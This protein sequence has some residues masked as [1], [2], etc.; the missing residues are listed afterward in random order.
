MKR[1]V[2]NLLVSAALLAAVVWFL[3]GK[4]EQFDA[5]SAFSTRECDTSAVLLGQDVE[6]LK[7]PNG[8]TVATLKAGRPIYL[9]ASEN[10]HRRVVFPN[11][12]TAADCTS[13]TSNTCLSGFVKEP[14]ETTILG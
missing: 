14:F 9:C 3:S 4:E 10:G 11:P 7:T 6:V 2:L 5:A 1:T 8:S 12:G 13:R